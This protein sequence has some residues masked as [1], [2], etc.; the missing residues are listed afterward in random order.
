MTMINDR[1]TFIGGGNMA[2]S[3]IGGLIGDGYDKQSIRVSDPDN[4]KLEVLASRFGIHTTHSNSDAVR[5]GDIIILAVKPQVMGEVTAGLKE[6]VDP[7]RHLVISIAA[8]IRTPVMAGW[9]G[10]QVPVVR[11]MPNTPAL[12]QSGATALF[13]N[14]RVS[15]AQRDAAETVMRSVGLTLWL[16]D[17]DQMDMVTA[18]SGCGP[19]YF[20]LVMECLENAARRLGLPADLTRLLTL[21]TAFGAAKLA[22]ESEEDSATLRARVTSPGGATEEA[23]KVLQQG[24]LQSLFDRALRA[25]QLRSK[26]LADQLGGHDG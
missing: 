10:E 6:A 19:A 22:L 7:A 13:A 17:E 23:I 4:A 25:A 5:H 2:G 24:D 1:I 26:D 12:V 11:A 15:A 20:F 8:G 21:Q 18:L 14:P 16:D 3:L 9:L